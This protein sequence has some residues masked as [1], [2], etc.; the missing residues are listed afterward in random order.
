M[1][2]HVEKAHARVLYDSIAACVACGALL[3][4]RA[5]HLLCG[6]AH[7]KLVAQAGGHETDTAALGPKAVP[8]GVFHNGRKLALYSLVDEQSDLGR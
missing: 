2:V 7:F 1:P 8:C 5:A 6:E 4:R 3:L